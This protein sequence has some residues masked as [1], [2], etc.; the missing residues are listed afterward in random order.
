MQETLRHATVRQES[1][2]V[3]APS[4]RTRTSSPARGI[5]LFALLLAAV[6]GAALSPGSARAD[7]ILP[8]SVAQ[9][10]LQTDGTLGPDS[11]SDDGRFVVFTSNDPA[12][13]DKDTNG[14]S[15]VFLHDRLTDT[16][17]LVSHA[18][19]NPTRAGDRPS[20]NPS[21]SGDGSTVVFQS[22]ATN[23]LP[24]AD[25]NGGT[26]IF[27]WD[28]ATGAITL[29]SHAAGVSTSGNSSSIDPKISDD[30]SFVVFESYAT[31]MT[32]GSDP[33][34]SG[35]D[36]FVWER[37]TG[38]VALVS[39][40]TAGLT[41]T[42]NAASGPYDIS[43]DGSTVVFRTLGTD[44][45]SGT[46]SNG[47]GD[48]YAW[49]R[50]SGGLTLVSHTPGNPTTTGNANSGGP[51]VNQDGSRVAFVS[52]ATDLT[53][54]TDGNGG[55]DVFLWT[56]GSGVVRLLSRSS[57]AAATGN[58]TSGGDQIDADGSV[59]VF[60]SEA[61]DLV[62]GADTNGGRDVFRWDGGTDTVSLV[63]HATGEA[64]A[65]GNGE[66]DQPRLSADGCIV[67][68]LGSATD[69]VAGT[70][71]TNGADDVFRWDCSTDT[72]T[73][74]SHSTAGVLVAGNAPSVGIQLNRDG[75]T[76]AFRSL[77]GDLVDL[78]GPGIYIFD[79]ASGDVLSRSP[80]GLAVTHTGDRGSYFGSISDDGRYVAFSSAATDLTPEL[81]TNTGLNGGTDV[82]FWDRLTGSVT[83]VSRSVSGA[84]TGNNVSFSAVVSGDGSAVVFS[85][86]A[87]N[88]VA[89]SDTNAKED[90]FV[91]DRA[92]DVT[93]LVSHV[94]GD[95]TTAGNGSCYDP[96]IS[97][98]GSGVAFFSG[99]T[100]LV[101]GTDTNGAAYDTFYWDRTSGVVT[102]ASHVPG[103]PTTSGNSASFPGN[104]GLAISDDG[105]AVAFLSVATDLVGGADTNGVTDLFL[106]SRT[107]GVVSLVSHSAASPTT[108]GNDESNEFM[109]SGDGSAVAFMN[110]SGNLLSGTFS[111]GY[112]HV[113]HWDRATGTVRLV[114]H[115]AGDP[116]TI[117]NSGGS[118]PSI[119]DD[120]SEVAFSSFATDLVA[121]TT[122]GF[123]SNV[124]LW[125]R[126]T[127]AS[128]LV[129]HGI[130]G[131]TTSGNGSSYQSS[132][133][134]DGS[135]VLFESGAS[136]LVEGLADANH[137]VDLFVSSAAPAAADLE[138]TKVATPDPVPPGG[139]L[140]Y[141]LTARNLGP[142]DAVRVGLFDPLP[143]GA[144]FVSVNGAG[145]SCGQASGRVA[146]ELAS[147]AAGETS[148]P[149]TI[150]V[151]APAT[152][153]TL[154]NTAITS[155]PGPNPTVGD[156]SATA[157]AAILDQD[158]GDAPDPTYPTLLA[159]DGARHSLDGTLYL[160]AAADG[161][162]DG[163]P[164]ATATG[165]DSAGG[166][167]DDGVSFGSALV[168]G[169]SASVTVVASAAGV[170]DAWVDWNADGDWSDPGEKVFDGVALGAGSNLLTIDVPQE[171][172]PGATYARFR[173]SSTGVALP[174]GP[175]A[176]GEVEDYQVVVAPAGAPAAPVEI[177]TAGGL[178]L[179]LLFSVLALYGAVALRPMSP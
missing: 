107:T 4:A 80:A 1:A 51:V 159:S 174:T 20:S 54:E 172:V 71:D 109:L 168:Q 87:D 75:S 29:A 3:T 73:L 50:A 155:W 169:E 173:L 19:G 121:G 48:V 39:H 116:T 33:N 126:G 61:T 7:D 138:L 49:D 131:T 45:I 44:L 76:V 134:G 154:T 59:V 98:D 65:A 127:G 74:A 27:L 167:D 22:I 142:A 129:S 21:I 47:Q 175:A 137:T 157:T 158:F 89:G 114:S 148:A 57:T 78:G 96:E 14:A 13:A 104:S 23:L 113:Y 86:R 72:T 56:R 31:D 97:D 41:T 132:L 64:T 93:T 16:L 83:L 144:T 12:L 171:A 37:A 84:T 151:I 145:W 150:R 81:D 130:A 95:A 24:G 106:W 53:A 34:G 100:D 99:A 122:G 10:S 140:T 91:W 115:T 120:G 125:D 70:T 101:A 63:S 2:D 6:L 112:D 94:A 118:E 85:S 117:A 124:Y 26:D 111:G 35:L 156:D 90:I 170:L 165:D 108:T 103:A 147:L 11:V 5:Q 58:G 141:T 164:N 179:A 153:G 77:A 166:N 163:Q 119:S 60:H 66:A 68:F 62:P 38:T 67:A 88:L 123:V 143:A 105:S 55:N 128:T 46:D 36:L 9:L 176:G 69:L 160:G 177:P 178:G 135:S 17:T 161:E 52:A 136:D 28:R 139:A 25:T 162:A 40:S 110:R 42:A 18:Y 32:A 102:L 30:A 79:A 152:P 8:V 15:D 82:F 149:V 43:G 133:S 92:T 146:C